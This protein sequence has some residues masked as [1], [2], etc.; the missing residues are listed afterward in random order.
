MLAHC[1]WEDDTY[2]YSTVIGCVHH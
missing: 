1:S 2:R